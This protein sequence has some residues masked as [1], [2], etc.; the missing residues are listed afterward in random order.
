MDGFAAGCN[1]ES[2]SPG[3]FGDGK[4]YSMEYDSICYGGNDTDLANF[5]KKLDEYFGAGNANSEESFLNLIE[6]E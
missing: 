1:V 2:F 3:S 4:H 6:P 5:A